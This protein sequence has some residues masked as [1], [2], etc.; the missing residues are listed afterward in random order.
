MS[1]AVLMALGTHCFIFPG[2][3]QLSHI[4]SLSMLDKVLF[5]DIFTYA[6]DYTLWLAVVL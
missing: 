1:E 2:F 6:S 5:Q 3:S 4:Q